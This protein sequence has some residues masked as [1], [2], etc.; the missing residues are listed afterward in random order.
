MFF[1]NFPENFYY[2]IY[3]Q[4]GRFME[5]SSRHP[6]ENGSFSKIDLE[7][8]YPKNPPW[9]LDNFFKNMVWNTVQKI[10]NSENIWMSFPGFAN[11]G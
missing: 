1:E 7:I 9:N 10:E 8:S 2:Y 6:I 3:V 11:K 4:L 5:N